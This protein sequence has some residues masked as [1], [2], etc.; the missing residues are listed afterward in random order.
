MFKINRY[1]KLEIGIAEF[2]NAPLSAFL[3]IWLILDGNE[4]R[5][6]FRELWSFIFAIFG[7][8][9]NFYFFACKIINNDQ[10]QLFY[11]NLVIFWTIVALLMIYLHFKHC[12]STFGFS[13]E[14]EDHVATGN[15]ST[16]QQADFQE[17]NL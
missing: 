16:G 11:W 13:D 7:V 10:Y 6:L 5:G 9:S 3:I 17:T 12:N 2:L 1:L 14:E 15:S 4:F 8:I